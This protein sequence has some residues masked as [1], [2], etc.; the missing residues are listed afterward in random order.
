MET[1]Y[2][3][4]RQVFNVYFEKQLSQTLLTL[5]FLQDIVF[6]LIIPLL[7]KKMC[8]ILLMPGRGNPLLFFRFF[9]GL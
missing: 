1:E 8:N 3:L 6:P 7:S 2:E 4:M 9:S 5:H